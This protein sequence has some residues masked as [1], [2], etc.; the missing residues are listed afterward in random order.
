[1]KLLKVKEVADKTGLTP[2]E[3]Y[4]YIESGELP[5]VTIGQKKGMRILERDVAN[6]IKEKC[7]PHG[8]STVKLRHV[9]GSKKMC[10]SVSK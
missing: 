3:I 6:F 5:V 2:R 1:M 7:E 9:E 10:I 8:A 4:K